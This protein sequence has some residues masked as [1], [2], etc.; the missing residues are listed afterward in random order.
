MTQRQYERTLILF[1][2]VM[3]T[4]GTLQL[5]DEPMNLSQGGTTA[6]TMGP[7]NCFMTLSVYIYNL[8]FKYVPNFGYAATVSYVIVFIIGLLTMVQFWAGRSDDEK[9]ER[10]NR[11][12]MKT[13]ILEKKGGLV[14][15]KI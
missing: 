8:C 11:K 1:T 12:L 9:I 14:H 13:K 2:T 4:I 15:E 3:S 5:F 10:R 6:A 7:G